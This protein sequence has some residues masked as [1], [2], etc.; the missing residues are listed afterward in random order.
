MPGTTRS[1]AAAATIG[2]RGG[3]GDDALFG[4]AGRD[5]LLGGQDNDL[6]DGGDGNDVLNGGGDGRDK[7]RIVCGEGYDVVVL[8]RNDVVLVE[9][10]ASE[11]PDEESAADDES[12]DDE[13]PGDKE[14]DD[15]VLEKPDSA[16]DDG[17]EKVKRPGDGKACASH[18]PACEDGERA[19]PATKGEDRGGMSATDAAASPARTPARRTTAAARRRARIRARRPTATAMTRC[20]D[21]PDADRAVEDPEPDED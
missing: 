1:T 6:L 13:A 11:H 18:R 21:E 2:V 14:S 17:C 9:V 15:T 4:G 10:Q 7:D 5:R 8:G 16:G 3:R 19:C 20:A 12:A